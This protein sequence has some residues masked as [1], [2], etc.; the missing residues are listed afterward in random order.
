MMHEFSATANVS[1]SPAPGEA[2]F[3]VSTGATNFACGLMV[4]GCL[5]YVLTVQAI[6]LAIVLAK[7]FGWL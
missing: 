2:Q 5:Y 1:Q 3:K 6:L 7:W 4:T